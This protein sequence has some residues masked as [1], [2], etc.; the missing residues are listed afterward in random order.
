MRSGSSTPG[1]LF[2]AGCGRAGRVAME[3]FHQHRTDTARPMD[4]D[5]EER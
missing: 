2:L 3:A 4:G 1:D 5:H